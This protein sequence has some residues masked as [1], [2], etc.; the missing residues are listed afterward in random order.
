MDDLY[1][2]SFDIVEILEDGSQK[3]IAREKK[4]TVF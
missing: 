1:F 3:K 2:E 4:P